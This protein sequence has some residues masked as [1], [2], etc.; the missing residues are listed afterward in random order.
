MVRQRRGESRSDD[1]RRSAEAQRERRS[2]RRAEDRQRARIALAREAESRG[3]RVAD[4]FAR[5]AGLDRFLSAMDA[6]DETASRRSRDGSESE[7]TS[8]FVRTM[9][10]LE[11]ETGPSEVNHDLSDD[12]ELHF[13]D[14]EMPSDWDATQ[15]S[16]QG[17][18]D[19]KAPTTSL[20]SQSSIDEY[21][22]QS[23]FILE[24]SVGAVRDHLA[25]M[26]KRS[27]CPICQSVELTLLE[28]GS[29]AVLTWYGR[30]RIPRLVCRCH[31]CERLS[32]MDLLVAGFLSAPRARDSSTIAEVEFL[33][34]IT[35]LRL[36]SSKG[37]GSVSAES[38]RATMEAAEARREFHGL[39]VGFQSDLPKDFN[40][41]WTLY[42]ALKA[43][44][45]D[46]ERPLGRLAA[47]SGFE[48]LRHFRGGPL[49]CPCCSRVPQCVAESEE[50]SE[51]APGLLSDTEPVVAVSVDGNF[52]IGQLSKV[53][54]VDRRGVEWLGRVRPS[55]R[56]TSMALDSSPTFIRAI[57]RE[58]EDWRKARAAV[59]GLLRDKDSSCQ[60]ARNFRASTESAKVSDRYFA[61][62]V[63]GVS[64]RHG[65]TT[66][67][68]DVFTGESLAYSALL[69]HWLLSTGMRLQ[70]FVYDIACRIETY[71]RDYFEMRPLPGMTPEESREV[72]SAIPKCVG[73]MHAPAHVIE[74]A[75][76]NCIRYCSNVGLTAG[77]DMETFWASL[78][79]L[80]N[81]VKYM[82]RANRWLV[83]ET[84]TRNY[85]SSKRFALPTLLIKRL[86]DA[87]QRRASAEGRFN[88][89][90]AE[91][92]LPEWA[93]SSP[94]MASWIE[95]D[96]ECR[97]QDSLRPQRSARSG[98]EATRGQQQGDPTPRELKYCE[99]LLR[100]TATNVALA[101]F[102]QN[103]QFDFFQANSQN[104][105]KLELEARL[106]EG[107]LGLESRWTEENPVFQKARRRLAVD[108]HVSL[109]LQLDKKQ[110]T[111]LAA[112]LKL[113]KGNFLPTDAERLRKRIARLKRS[114]EKARESTHQSGLHLAELGMDVPET[115]WT[116]G[117][118]QLPNNPDRVIVVSTSKLIE[119][120]RLWNEFQRASE[121]R[122]LTKRDAEALLAFNSFQ[123]YLLRVADSDAYQP[124]LSKGEAAVVRRHRLAME[125][126]TERQTLSLNPTVLSTTINEQPSEP[127][128][129]TPMAM[130]SDAD[131][132]GDDSSASEME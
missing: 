78:N 1:Q 79:F 51:A 120:R 54:A 89:V 128:T 53:A 111:L 125:R 77:E 39:E 46:V 13:S 117:S 123:L 104:I 38:I 106:Y 17:N 82:N 27:K 114:V 60:D 35:Q 67:L 3:L 97:V 108:N 102:T 21:I 29:W 110:T 58:L 49:P 50:I 31:T 18:P 40:E 107:K 118:I 70:A 32:R 26:L 103:A 91:I 28:E 24:R 11:A 68:Q 16:A 23:A 132:S 4:D 43:L 96:V 98:A 36:G 127:G 65:S 129:S 5:A 42:L 45:D 109:L 83:I 124:T 15:H 7:P 64:C 22:A 126:L 2:R 94:G 37:A 92:G 87:D 72:I 9:P 56:H 130:I 59:G 57:S 119:L 55:M 122:V 8:Q 44:V 84:F 47:V 66:G 30:I 19:P 75:I 105:E 131:S 62:G 74:C 121:E 73:A 52:K 99:I 115:A 95:S 112:E 90:L 41:L 48:P 101:A 34:T 85:N 93:L 113:S 116:D 10:S 20:P 80:K 33:E 14:T 12:P 61:R 71:F 86:K 81:H 25:A 69:L 100:L 63:L 76:N 6:V 88:E